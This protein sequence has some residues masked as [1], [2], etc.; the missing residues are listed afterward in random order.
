MHD[1]CSNSGQPGRISFVVQHAV[2]GQRLGLRRR[3]SRAR[4]DLAVMLPEHRRPAHAARGSAWPWRGWAARGLPGWAR[5]PW[6]R[7]PTSWTSRAITP[8]GAARSATPFGDF[9]MRQQMLAD[10]VM[11]IH[12]ARL[13]VLHAAWLI[14]SGR[15]ARE[16]IST[17]KVRAAETLGRVVDRAVRTH[18]GTGFCKGRPRSSAAAGMRASAASST[19][20]PGSTAGSSVVGCAGKARRCTTSSGRGSTSDRSWNQSQ[21]VS[22]PEPG[23]RVAHPE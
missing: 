13:M 11:V 21:N 6:A 1:S 12:S 7:P 16:G 8:G 23:S 17:V 4:S 19:A 5:A 14:D 22:A 9:E 3:V 15:E 2:A 10:S 18:G 20:R